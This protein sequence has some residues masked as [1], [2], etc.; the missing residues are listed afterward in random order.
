MSEQQKLREAVARAMVA[1]DSGPEGSMLFDL[2]W[3]EFGEGYLASADAAIAVA[4]EEAARIVGAQV[5]SGAVSLADG[6]RRPMTDVEIELL[7][8]FARG[9]EAQ[10][11]ALKDKQP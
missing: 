9:K 6:T 5:Q 8:S 2:H 7:R 1:K 10:I 4:L 11:R 3:R